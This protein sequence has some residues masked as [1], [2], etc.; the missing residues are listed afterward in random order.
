MKHSKT[1]W[2]ALGIVA[3]LSGCGSDGGADNDGDG[4]GGTTAG[5]TSGDT[6]GSSG[7]TAGSTGSAEGGANAAP[8]DYL[9]EPSKCGA[10]GTNDIF[11]TSDQ[12]GCYYFYCYLT[13]AQL[14]SEA[15]PGGACS[16]AADLAAQC[17]GSIPKVVAECARGNVLSAG[18]AE[19]FAKVINEC[20]KPKLPGVSD[21]CLAC[22]TQS[23]VCA[24]RFENCLTLCSTDDTPECDKCRQEKGCTPD[25]Y[26][27]AGLPDPMMY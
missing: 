8:G 21:G 14:K 3:A 2:L 19:N 11:D 15:T 17:E 24:G 27:C 22:N 18:N 10:V 16:S 12:G 1:T 4:T 20:A 9:V 23:A 25:F 26:K 6:G 13:E 7:T 5:N